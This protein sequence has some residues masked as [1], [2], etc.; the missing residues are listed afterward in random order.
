MAQPGPSAQTEGTA[1][2]A[3]RPAQPRARLG[4]A[5]AAGRGRRPGRAR[6]G[7]VRGPARSGRER[8][9]ARGARLGRP[10]EG[11]GG[12]ASGF[13][14]CE[15]G[16]RAAPGA[17]G[18]GIALG[19]RVA[20]GEGEPSLDR[21]RLPCSGRGGGE[22]WRCIQVDID[23]PGVTPSLIWPRRGM[24]GCVRKG[25]SEGAGRDGQC[26]QCV[27]L[28]EKTKKI[29]GLLS[30]WYVPVQKEAK[31][32]LKVPAVERLFL[33]GLRGSVNIFFFT[34][35][36]VTELCAYKKVVGNA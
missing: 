25:T 1:G 11:A 10:W 14:G 30:R 9:A 29:T 36:E 34:L 35:E 22:G 5:P 32:S 31:L 27:L 6:P 23:P 3:V 28:L 2:A 15:C 16:A 24:F 8:G 20:A 7:R 19:G 12:S 26:E 33:S 13:L 21:T 4:A 18:A 17:H